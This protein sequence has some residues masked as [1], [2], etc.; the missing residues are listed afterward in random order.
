MKLPSFSCLGSDEVEY[1]DS[2]FGSG[3]FV[4]F[5]YPKDMTSGCTREAQDFRDQLP[6]FQAHGV[7]VYGA[8]KDPLKSHDKF[9]E[10]ENLNFILLSDPE[11]KLLEALGAWK[12]KSMYGRKYMGC[13]RSTFVISK[14]EIVKEWRKVKVPGHVDEVLDWV[15]ENL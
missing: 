10:K 13:E 1:T 15:K 6:Q 9:I 3:H 14:G 5:L 8:S 11:S 2:N 4:L 12:E 7:E